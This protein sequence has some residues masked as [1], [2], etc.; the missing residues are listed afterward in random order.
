MIIL[1]DWPDF[2][3]DDV[4]EEDRGHETECWVWAHALPPTSRTVTVRKKVKRLFN[5]AVGIRDTAANECWM[6][7]C[8]R[9][10]EINMCVRPDHVVVASRSANSL[11]SQQLRREAGAVR[12][13]LLIG[14]R[15]DPASIEKQAVAMRGRPKSDEHR[16]NIKAAH[17]RERVLGPYPCPACGQPFVLPA[18]R[19]RH[20]RHQCTHP[21]VDALRCS[22]AA[23]DYD[24]VRLT[25]EVHR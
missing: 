10:G 25:G 7:L 12:P 24:P 18:Q 21:D 17:D 11:H 13:S 6:H 19:T 3:W 9:W 22:T 2:P 4:F 20:V 14:R 15:R 1:P 5:V 23:E 16:A 8:E